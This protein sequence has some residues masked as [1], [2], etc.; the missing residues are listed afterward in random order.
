MITRR[1]RGILTGYLTVPGNCLK[2]WRSQPTPNCFSLSE[3][4]STAYLKPCIPITVQPP[5]SLRKDVKCPIL[6]TRSELKYYE[7]VPNETLAPNCPQDAC[8][9]LW[10]FDLLFYLFF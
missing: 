9:S 1:I 8:R 10:L 4:R 6:E 2:Y 7:A 3:Y 5:H